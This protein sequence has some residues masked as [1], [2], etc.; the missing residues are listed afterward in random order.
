MAAST[1]QQIGGGDVA[2][3]LS[4]TYQEDMLD[5]TKKTA[6][7]VT[8]LKDAVLAPGPATKKLTPANK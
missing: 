4:G 8:Q 2:S 3:I 7:S 1:L 6:D 5:A